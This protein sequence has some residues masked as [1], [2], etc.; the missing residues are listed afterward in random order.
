M[1]PP[2]HKPHQQKRRKLKWR[3]KIKTVPVEPAEDVEKTLTKCQRC[4]EHRNRQGKF[5]LL[6]NDGCFLCDACYR[7]EFPATAMLDEESDF[8]RNVKDI[9]HNITNTILDHVAEMKQPRQDAVGANGDSSSS[10]SFP[11]E[12]ECRMCL[13]RGFFRTCCKSYYCHQCYFQSGQC[14]KCNKDTPLTG[15]AAALNKEDPGRL[16][17]GVSWLIS[18]LIIIIAITAVALLCWNVSTFPV[19][20]SANQCR[21]WLPTCNLA[22]C[23]EHN[24]HEESGA[25]LPATQPY[26]DCDRSTSS[27]QVIASACVYD[28]EAYIWS[29]H[30]IGYDICISS[31]R[32]EHSRSASV[33]SSKPLLLYSNDNAG[34]YVFDDDFEF[35]LKEASAPW[36]EIINGKYSDACGVNRNPSERGSHGAFSPPDNKNALVFGGRQRRHATTQGLNVESGG[37]VEFHLKLGPLIQNDLNSECQAAFEGDV[38]LE[39]NTNSAWTTIGTYPAWK[40]RGEAFQFISEIIPSDARTNS[41]QFRIRQPKFDE[42]RD[43]WAIDDFRVLSRLTP[44]WQYSEEYKQL[45][46]KQSEDVKLAQCCLDTNLCSFFDKKRISF[47]SD[48]CEN[49][50]TA[51][52]N[53]RRLKTPELLILFT[54]LAAVGKVLYRLVSSR[55]TRIVKS[56][57]KH[58]TNDDS[59]EEGTAL[60]PHKKFSAISSLSWQYSLT[61]LLCGIMLLTIYRLLSASMVFQCMH[62]ENSE[63]PLCRTNDVSFYIS[64]FAAFCLDARV[65][66]MLLTKVFFVENPRNRKA[67]EVEVDLHPE[68]RYMRI[69]TGG[70]VPVSEITELQAKSRLFSWI[71]SSCY[72]MGGLPLA[73]GSL[74]I[75]SF[76]LGPELDVLSPILGSLALLREVFGLSLFAK[77]WLCVGWVFAFRVDDRKEFGRAVRRK[78]LL[79]QFLVGFCLTPIVVMFTLLIRRVEYVSSTDNLI[80]FIIFAVSGGLFGLLVGVFRGLPTTPDA[81]LTSWPRSCYGVTYY[82]KVRCPCIFSWNYCGEI[83]SRQVL[84]IISL[85]DMHSFRKSLMGNLSDKNE[86]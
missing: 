28:W 42:M 39:Y 72:V 52:T 14:P 61:F 7:H 10:S 73:L 60:F 46:R 53:L 74:T 58:L 12:I 49:I 31:P 86:S 9:Q 81:Y 44:Q 51:K 24:E 78:G 83:H 40:Y 2:Q 5:R 25:F 36:Q 34:V 80:L 15:L 19:T 55:F 47:D 77:F 57:L 59:E 11:S 48:I 16:A 26:N 67:L 66:G 4:P 22:V 68:R 70:V 21:G 17:V 37:T 56:N 6:I 29:N 62:R 33:S 50:S 63:D 1:P 76:E 18:V 43:H 79:Q 45:G 84:L 41:T 8:R 75:Q 85:D 38:V 30:S 13:E 35:P 64:S 32:E 71:V 54:V 20:I 82:E 27:H 65:V 3:D 69:G 23:I